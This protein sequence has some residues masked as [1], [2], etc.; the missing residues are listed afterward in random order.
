MNVLLTH[1]QRET[2]LCLTF[3]LICPVTVYLVALVHVE[4]TVV[5]GLGHAKL[6]LGV[7][8]HASTELVKDVKV[9]LFGVL[10]DDPRFFQKKIGN[11]AT[12]WQTTGEDDL[13]I[14]ALV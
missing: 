1:S 11:L 6:L 8:V 9:P 10:S 5:V 7:R 14:L 4:V 13:D 12:H 3:T 2:V